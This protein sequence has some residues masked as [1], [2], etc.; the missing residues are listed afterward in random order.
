MIT[1]ETLQEFFDDTRAMKQSGEAQFDI[2]DVCR[3]SFFFTDSDPAKLVAVAKRLEA[4]GYEYV[5]LLE[6]SPED[7]DQETI[8]M[9]C[10]RVERHT[11][12]SLIQ[13]SS[14]F[15]ALAEE[16]ELESYDG[17]DVGHV[18]GP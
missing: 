11:I 5:G 18:D 12:D 1:R 17:M 14:E 15:C 8:Y 13:R 3:W 4:D 16:A 6:P 7:D 10:D 2:D 9:R